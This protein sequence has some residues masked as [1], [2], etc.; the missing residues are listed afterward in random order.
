M[1]RIVEMHKLGY[2]RRKIASDVEYSIGT[3]S[4]YAAAE[5]QRA[6]EVDV[7]DRGIVD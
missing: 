7:Q 5:D 6:G 3:V 1:D 4:K 2:T